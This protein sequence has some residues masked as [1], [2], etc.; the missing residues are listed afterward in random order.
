MSPSQSKRGWFTGWKI[1]YWRVAC[2]WKAHTHMDMA[3]T[4]VFHAIMMLLCIYSTVIFIRVC[5]KL[6]WF[7]V[8]WGHVLL[9]FPATVSCSFCQLVLHLKVNKPSAWTTPKHQVITSASTALQLNFSCWVEMR[10]LNL[11]CDWTAQRG[12]SSCHAG[13][14]V[15]DPYRCVDLWQSQECCISM[16]QLSIQ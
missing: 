12:A 7:C 15:H 10:S 1:C 9:W 16:M 13:A 2:R 5:S 6:S 14:R 11:N 4:P 8:V 3:V